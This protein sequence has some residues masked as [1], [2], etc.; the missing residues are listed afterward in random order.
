MSTQTL[1]LTVVGWIGT[2]PKIF[3]ESDGQVPYATF[4]VGSTR[5]WFDKGIGAW[6]DAQTEWFHVKVFRAMAVNA[7]RSLRKGDPVIVQGQLST[8]EWAGPEGPRT[9]LVLEASALGHNLV[10]GSSH[11]ART[12]SAAAAAGADDAPADVSDLEEL[13]DDDGAGLEPLEALGSELDVE[14]ELALAA[15][16]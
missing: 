6:R 7:A 9:T 1:D 16:R 12:V 8:E 14:P 2:E 11:F 3:H 5:R 13:P 10:F 15:A 4:R